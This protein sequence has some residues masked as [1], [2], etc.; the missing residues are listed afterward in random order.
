[1]RGELQSLS[2]SGDPVR[3]E[4]TRAEAQ[5]IRPLSENQGTEDVLGSFL[6][7]FRAQ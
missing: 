7:Y 1:M 5:Q 3:G 4:L 6:T 2:L